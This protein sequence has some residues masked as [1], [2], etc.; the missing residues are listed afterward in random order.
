MVDSSPGGKV[1]H[2]DHGC[3]MLGTG[4]MPGRLAKLFVELGGLLDQ[5]QPDQVAV[6]SIF[7]A[8]NANSAF[9]LGQARGVAL[10]SAAIKGLSIA[11][12]SPASVKQAV[13]GRGRADKHQVQHMIRLLLGLRKNVQED[14]ADA[15]AVCLCHANTAQ[16][17]NALKMAAEK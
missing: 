1:S 3:I 4:D 14:A 9:K 5:Y 12:Y 13:V 7:M 6:E 15:L 17:N 8:K 16:T 2:V 11:E 10:C